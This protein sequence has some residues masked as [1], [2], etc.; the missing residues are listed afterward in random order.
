MAEIRDRI[1]IAGAGLAGARTAQELRAHGY[2]GE[3]TLLGSEPHLPYDRPPLSKELLAGAVDDTTLDIPWADLAVDLRLSVRALALTDGGVATSAGPLAC[4]AVVA[5]T[6]ADPVR[7][8]G[9]RH[10]LVLRTI[11]DARR[12]RS[13]LRAG[14]RVIILGAG[15]IGAEV[16]TAATHAGAAVTVVEAG[17]APLAA[18]LGERVGSL[19]APWYAAAGVELHCGVRVERVGPGE[20]RLADGRRLGA[21]VVL[22]GLGVRPA[23]GWLA[24]SGI[25]RATVEP[26]GAVV[27]DAAGRSSR[28]GVW[29]VGDCARRW[30]PRAG[31]T[32]W[33][34]HWDDAL[35]APAAVAAAIQ[36][37]R[38]GSGGGWGGP[39]GGAAGGGA[40][41]DP[42]PYFWSEQFGRRLQ[43]VGWRTGEPAVWRGR[44]ETD[45]G[46]AAGWLDGAGRLVGF[47]AVDRARDVAPARRAIAAGA[48]PDPV[49]LADPAVAVRA[50]WDT[51][52]EPG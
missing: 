20:V 41:Y 45:A 32:V 39:A 47:L 11:D 1:V 9:D 8:A 18:P 46:W 4:A 28:P 35:R 33:T 31:A 42:V 50:T 44:P 36:S 30:S 24:G 13:A 51:G 10:S 29:A 21:D 48:R 17:S 25:E 49:R 37:D 15:W 14:V 38:G 16:A 52:R 43:W 6:G 3:L 23:T 40:G 2:G 22:S 5:A 26:A 34:G 19:T 27:T 7:L 12:L